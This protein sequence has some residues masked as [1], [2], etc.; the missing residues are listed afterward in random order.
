MPLILNKI[1]ANV[2]SS[3]HIIETGIIY[4]TIQRKTRIH[5]KMY[6]SNLTK[7]LIKSKINFT[8]CRLVIK[9]TVNVLNC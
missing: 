4:N 8:N 1:I 2:S 9:L 5:Y 3:L 7:K 6:V